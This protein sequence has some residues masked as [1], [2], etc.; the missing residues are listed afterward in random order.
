MLHH[1][2]PHST[3]LRLPGAHA[4]FLLSPTTQDNIVQAIGQ[5]SGSLA[6]VLLQGAVVG[7]NACR[8]VT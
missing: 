6:R 3:I 4:D 7:G 8:P 1:D 5:V 2:A